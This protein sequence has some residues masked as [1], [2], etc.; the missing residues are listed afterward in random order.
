MDKQ[1]VEW[2]DVP[3]LIRIGII[4][5]CGMMLYLV[6]VIVY[7]I[8]ESAGYK[9]KWDKYRSTNYIYVREMRDTCVG[10]KTK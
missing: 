3:L 9:A 2:K 6:G 7:D 10:N 1:K 5:L 8:G 4:V